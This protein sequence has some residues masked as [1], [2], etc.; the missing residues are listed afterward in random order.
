MNALKV[1]M[2]TR[3]PV[4]DQQGPHVPASALKLWFRELAEPVIPQSLYDQCIDVREADEGVCWRPA[5]VLRC[6]QACNDASAAIALT[7]QLPEVNKTLV[8]FITRFLQVRVVLAVSLGLLPCLSVA[9]LPACL[10]AC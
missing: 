3:E 6:L 8:L 1:K 10:P 2:D 7:D 9:C 5:H 4:G